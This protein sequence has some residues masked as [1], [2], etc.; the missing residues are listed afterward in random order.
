MTDDLLPAPAFDPGSV[1]L[2]F[3]KEEKLRM[4]ALMLAT[5]Y[6]TESVIKEGGLYN[7]MKMS[8]ENLRTLTPELVVE[9]AIIFEKY[10]TTGQMTIVKRPDG[11]EQI[12][13]GPDAPEPKT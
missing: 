8:G 4:T 7:A 13:I 10:L 11:G 12:I 2:D 5:R 1:I 3:N 9:T 6:H